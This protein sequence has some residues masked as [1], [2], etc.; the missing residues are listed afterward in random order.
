MFAPRLVCPRIRPEK[1]H[2]CF[3]IRPISLRLMLP[4]QHEI[5]PSGCRTELFKATQRQMPLQIVEGI[6]NNLVS[7]AR[8]AWINVIHCRVERMNAASVGLW[9]PFGN[10]EK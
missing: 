10:V 8:I 6:A 4:G 3:A 1:S 7:A 9:R 2:Q 5:L